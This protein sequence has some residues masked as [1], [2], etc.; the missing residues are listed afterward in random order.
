[1]TEFQYKRTTPADRRIIQ[2]LTEAQ[3]RVYQLDRLNDLLAQVIPANQFYR[4][5]FAAAGN[6][7]VPPKLGSLAELS[8]LP[9]TTKREL[10]NK[11]D[12]A[13]FANNLTFSPDAYTRFHRTSGTSGR[14]MIVLDTQNDWNWWM[15]AWQYVLD[16]ASLT[17][18]DR[19]LMAFSFGPFIGFWSAFDAVAERGAMVIRLAR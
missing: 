1:M 12:S 9:F 2:S 19:V 13:G 4:D 8:Q 15:E 6:S 11:S 17:K 5:K 10:I 3:R 16:S 7:A 14:P 18:Q